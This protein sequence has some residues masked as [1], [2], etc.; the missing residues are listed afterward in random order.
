MSLEVVEYDAAPVGS[1]YINKL[2]ELLENEN[3]ENALK[4]IKSK[5]RVKV[6]PGLND[7]RHLLIPLEVECKS[8]GLGRLPIHTALSKNAPFIV[9]HNLVEKYPASLKVKSVADYDFLPLHIACAY[10]NNKAIDV[11]RENV[12]QYLI[13]EYP[14]ALNYVEPANSSTALHIICEHQPSRSLTKFMISTSNS[15][16]WKVDEEGNLP[17]HTAIDYLADS[18][19]IICLLDIYKNSISHKRKIDGNTPLHCAAFNGCSERVLLKLVE[20]ENVMM[21]DVK[22]TSTNETPL[23]LIFCVEKYGKKF[24]NETGKAKNSSYA[25]VEFMVKTM[26]QRYYS[27]QKNRLGDESKAKQL[28]V[29]LLTKV[30]GD[31]SRT[32]MMLIN[33][34]NRSYRLPRN[35]LEKID[36]LSKGRSFSYLQQDES[37]KKIKIEQSGEDEYN[38]S[39]DEEFSE[40]NQENN[41]E[42]N[43]ETVIASISL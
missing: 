7:N 12:I 21:M 3:W 18:T 13:D 11:N 15:L 2:D 24:V 35:F 39:T 33:I 22:N 40:N 23:H 4:R 8:E 31:V 38:A 20:D 5:K 43:N 34:C 14:E 30:K 19:V 17:V 25:D 9:I 42:N 37:R 41:E 6:R 1:E 16:S 36:E 32:I 27:Y 10:P 26:L 28:V 29:K